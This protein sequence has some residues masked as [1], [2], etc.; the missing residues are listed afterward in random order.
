MRKFAV[1]MAVVFVLSV[2]LSGCGGSAQSEK[3][4]LYIYNWTEYMPQEVYD[5]FEQETGI[6]VIESTFSSNEEMLAKL[7]AGGTDQYDMVVASSYVINLMKEKSMIQTIDK[8][9]IENFKNI[10]PAVLG[11]DIDPNNEYSIPYMATMTV[12]AVNKEKLQE[13]GV[14]ITSLNDL[15]NPALENNLVVV[16]DSRELVGAALKATSQDIDTRDEATIEGTLDWLRD[17]KKNVKAFDSDSAK[18]LLA[19]NEVAA[20]FVYNI[21]A[22]QA[23][24]QNDQIT[25]VYTTEP[26]EAA[27]D[28]FVITSTS[29]HKEYAEAFINFVHRPEIYK[30][31][32]DEF[33]GVCLNDAA[34]ELLDSSYLDNAGSNVD[35]DELARAH[36]TQDIGDA[37]A[38]YDDVFTKMKSE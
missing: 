18:T 2:I 37:A 32:L 1:V 23:I 27:V 25:V 21:D 12:I 6:H 7:E 4:E 34:K 13:L 28:N 31:I 36:F 35:T 11:T 33:P 15:L 26:C 9:N 19:T 29:Q 38:Y 3:K 16:D 8:D 14:T 5:L 22:G 24:S 30:K 10:T 20:G 17:L